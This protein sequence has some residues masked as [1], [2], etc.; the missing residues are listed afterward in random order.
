M[1]RQML[2]DAVIVQKKLDVDIGPGLA[3]VEGATG[4]S[5]ALPGGADVKFL[6]I[7]IEDGKAGE[8]RP[9]LIGGGAI[10]KVQAAAAITRGADV[11]VNGVTGTF[12]IAA[13]GAGVNSYL[14]G[15][16]AEAAANAGDFIGVNFKP[17]WKQG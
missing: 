2:S 16:A 12:K 11:S 5:V 14:A 13:P 3:V 1:A 7:S 10:V 8:Y 4:D 15:D 9:I 17:G 6:G